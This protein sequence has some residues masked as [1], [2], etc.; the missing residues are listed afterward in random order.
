MLFRSAKAVLKRH[1]ACAS[2]FDYEGWLGWGQWRRG[3]ERAPDAQD[4]HC[5]RRCDYPSECRWGRVAAESSERPPPPLTTLAAILARIDRLGDMRRDRADDAPAD[6][7]WSGV[8]ASAC[9]RKGRRGK[10]PLQLNAVAEDEGGHQAAG[11]LTDVGLVGVD[12]VTGSPGIERAE[13]PA[14]RLPAVNEMP[15]FEA[16]LAGFRAAFEEFGV[17]P[18]HA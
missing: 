7:F 1:A 12:A 15:G 14:L 5:W 3:G 2:E 10:S 16:S 6:G 4:K 8:L 9:Q 18:D 13:G 11:S 17:D